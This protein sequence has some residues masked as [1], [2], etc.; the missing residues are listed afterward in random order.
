M[1]KPK[2][3]DDSQIAGQLARAM[4]A[5]PHCKTQTALAAK[6]GV[7]QASIGRILRGESVP[8][9]VVLERLATALEISVEQL[10]GHSSDEPRVSIRPV[11]TWEHPD[12]LPPGEFALIRRLSV[13]LSA[14]NGN[15]HIEAEPDETLQPQ[16]FRADWIR[17]MG[18]KPGKL[19]SLTADGDSMADRIQDGDALV[20]DLSQKNVIDG[21]VYAIWYNG[22]ERVKRLFCLPGGG[23]RIFSDNQVAYPPIDLQQGSLAHVHIIGRVVHVAGEGGL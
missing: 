17:K 6:S 8:G 14:G 18:L 12:E 21:K 19:A 15:D 4:E 16:A 5:H 7:S 20:V 13:K 2:I 22:G 10:L 1:A 9:A 3:S 23:L 11:L